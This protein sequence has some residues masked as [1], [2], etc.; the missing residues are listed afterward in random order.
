MVMSSE[1][2]NQKIRPMGELSEIAQDLKRAGKKVVL[3]HGVFDLLHVGHLRHFIAAKEQGD[4]LFVTI[5]KDEYVGKGPGRPVFNQRLRSE[6]VAALQC[7]DYVA[8]NEWH[9]AVETIKKLKPDVYVKGSDYANRT[10][11][12]T[13]EIFREEEAVLSVGGRVHFT[14]ELTF[15][16]SSL[17]NAYFDVYPEEAQAFLQEF[18]G[19]YS[20]NEVIERLK[21]LKGVKV[22]VVGDTI[23]DEY[24]Y[25][26]TLGKSTKDVIL[27]AK[28][29]EGE[30]F[31][32]GALAAANHVAG[33]CEQ[34]SLFTCLGADDDRE[35]FILRHLKPNVQAHFIHRRDAPT[36]VK[37]RYVEQ[38][39]MRKLFEVCFLDDHP[40]PEAVAHEACRFLKENIRNFDVVLVADF[41]HGFIGRN[42]VD[43]L[44]SE[45]KFLALNAQTNSANA[46]FN[47]VT[48]YPR[49]DYIC[50]DEPEIRLA[51]HSKFGALP[52]MIR[53]VAHTLGSDRIAVTR[54]HLGSV[55]YSAGEGFFETPVFSNQVIDTTGA[56]DA[57]LSITAHCVASG[58]PMDLVGFIGNAVGA[59]A[60]RIVGNRSPVEPVPL[61]KFITALLK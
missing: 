8:I 23:I 48:K 53:D 24:H 20:A 37:R 3:C 21:A 47:L 52:D 16:S 38:A 5:T 45:A 34:V 2:I 13:G 39:F 46:G 25:C 22:L 12:L 28:Y 17:L 1:D 44:C 50:I 15:S 56:G 41:G 14:D 9:T 4:V 42:I 30:A 31:A 40:L 11:D 6:F 10:D 27:T 61:S 60:V 57:Y 43:V 33:F 35:E 54:G 29:L 18:R 55:T 51:A 32:G 58:Y 59:L 7:V 19:R 36:V 49:A 26:R